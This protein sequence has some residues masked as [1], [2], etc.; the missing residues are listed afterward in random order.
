MKGPSQMREDMSQG[1]L[2]RS[3]P[4]AS[5]VIC[6]YTEDR[7]HQLTRAVNSALGQS[8]PPLEVVLVIDHCPPLLQR[9]RE[10]FADVVIVPNAR[11]RGLAGARN[12]GVARASGEVVAFLDDDAV[13]SPDWLERLLDAYADPAVVGVGGM[14]RPH[15]V[16]GRP[17]WFPDELGWVV[18]C[19]YRG[20]P[21]DP[22]PVR[23][24]IGANMS[25]RRGLLV[26]L[27][28]FRTGLGRIGTLP[29]G[30]E[31]TELCIRAA[32]TSGGG[33]VLYQP[34]ATVDHCVPAARASWSYL[35]SRCYAEGL[36]KAAVAKLT[37]PGP[38]LATERAYV[39]RAIPR[40]IAHGVGQACRGRLSGLL[41]A[42]ALFAGVAV[43][44][45]GY[46]A[47]RLKASRMAARLPSRSALVTE[48]AQ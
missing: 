34:M 10:S 19:S 31:E 36:S 27:G 6:A 8:Q 17:A 47:G 5:V 15:W 2:T 32:E 40:G 43:T 22:A 26:D 35:W 18:G 13:A 38:A 11:T 48:A 23:N 25:F 42:W 29:L 12:T 46:L 24:V 30:C 14:V 16:D 33:I 20:M 3:R 41:T 7:W 4:S 28:G 9:A 44:T 39:L 37:G 21:E 1:P 45:A